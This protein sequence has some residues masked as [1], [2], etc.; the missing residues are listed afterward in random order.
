MF[1]GT[2]RHHAEHIFRPIIGTV[3]GAEHI[4]A[5]GPFLLAANHIDYLDGFFITFAI[6]SRN[7]R[8]VKFLTETKNYWWTGGAAIPVNPNN[9]AKAL[10][11]A[12]QALG[13]GSI[14]CI[15]PEGARNPSN[16]LL[17]GRTGLARLALWS[18]VPVIPLGLIGKS[19]NTSMDS[20]RTYVMH[21]NSVKVR[22]GEPIIFPR[23]EREA[24]NKP[25]LERTTNTIMERVATLS[26]KTY[27]H[28]HTVE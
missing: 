10:Q 11:Q 5:N 9:K 12:E 19:G 21:G 7:K 25:L 27:N 16:Q 2:L 23:I 8:M 3:E 26:N 1:Y 18:N 13:H 28:A 14:I 24:I 15:F 22:I 20:I 4:P 6:I 17:P